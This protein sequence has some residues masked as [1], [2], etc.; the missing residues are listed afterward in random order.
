MEEYAV[1]GGLLAGLLGATGAARRC[2]RHTKKK[3]GKG[4]GCHSRINSI[5]T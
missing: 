3:E 1:I 2:V 5:P 4:N